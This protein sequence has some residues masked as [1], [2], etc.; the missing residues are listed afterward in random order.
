[1][2]NKKRLLPLLL[3]FTL[4]LTIWGCSGEPASSSGDDAG[5]GDGD[6]IVVGYAQVGAESDWRTANTVSFQDTFVEGNGYKLIFDDAQQKQENQIKAIRNFIQQDVDY[7]VLAPVV[8]SLTSISY[9]DVSIADSMFSF[10]SSSTASD[11]SNVISCSISFFEYFKYK[12]S[13]PPKWILVWNCYNF[14]IF[15]PTKSLFYSRN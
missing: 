5:G 14:Y 3:M 8:V 1:M 4:L 13:F 9:I 6:L 2:K 10:C 12:C 15:I 11:V 7:I